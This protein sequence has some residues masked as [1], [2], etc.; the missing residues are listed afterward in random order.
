MNNELNAFHRTATNFFSLVSFKQMNYDNLIAFA[1]GVQ[2]SGLNPVIVNKVDD[3][4]LT[5]LSSCQ[6]FYLKNNLPWALI[7]PEYLYNEHVAELLKNQGF[8]LADKGVA[9]AV[10]IEAINFPSFD[11]PMKIKEMKKDLNT[12]SLP[13]VA[14]DPA[15]ELSEEYPERHRLASESGALLYHFSGFIHDKVVCSLSLSFCDNKARIDDVATMPA[16]QKRGYAT[17]LIYAA[18]DYVK[19][20]NSTHCFLEASSSGLDLYKKIGFHE[21]FVNRYY[22]PSPII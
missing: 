20:L 15:S 14:F 16:Y 8:I 7:L 4:F 6:S 3:A 10:L 22:E 2:A 12:W 19:Q 17:Q 9:M 21:L 11:S 18:L 1:T 5:N 13:L